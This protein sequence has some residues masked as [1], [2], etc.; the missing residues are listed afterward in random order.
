M[1]AVVEVEG[2]HDCLLEE[3]MLEKEEEE[4]GHYTSW[5]EVEGV[6]EE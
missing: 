5:V 3:V 4:R 6:A 2:P 1:E